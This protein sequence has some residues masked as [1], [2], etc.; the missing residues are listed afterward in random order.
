MI[1]ERMI[2]R[3]KNGKF[4]ELKEV[5]K[6]WEALEESLGGFP[7]RR[8]YWAMYGAHDGGTYVWEREW[9]SLAAMEAAY[10]KRSA[11]PESAK[12]ARNLFMEVIS[13]G[14]QGPRDLYQLWS[15]DTEE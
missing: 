7:L 4:Q 2:H 15:T 3:V 9:E 1:L 13:I 12:T 10:D 5:E 6:K 14:E 8:R 11:D